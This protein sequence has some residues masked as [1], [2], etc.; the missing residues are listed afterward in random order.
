MNIAFLV[1]ATGKY[2]QF[3]K[4]LH[5]SIKKH[6]R[7]VDAKFNVFVFTDQPT[8]PFGCRRV[9]QEH[10]PFPYPTLMRYHMFHQNRRLYEG[11]DYI[12]YLD[13]DML[14]VGDVGKE[15]LAER[16]GVQHPGFYNKERKVFSYETRR[17]STACVNANEGTT[18][19]CGGFNGGRS[20]IY[21]TMA[22]TIAKR[23]DADTANNIVAL[24]HDESHLNR[25]YIDNKPTMILNP[26]YC[27]P[28]EKFMAAHGKNL[29]IEKFPKKIIAL[30]KDKA[31]VRV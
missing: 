9:Q 23:V 2:I 29:G 8:V 17:L 31:A 6:L 1:V 11:Y 3:V 28:G 30:D 10:K 20:S 14:L 21:L 25:Y 13:A 27:Y 19:F 4:P 16:L 5:D 18:Y 7:I 24:W 15:I 12:F 22:Q 26:S